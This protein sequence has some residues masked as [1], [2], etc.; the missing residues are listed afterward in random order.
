[1]KQETL[2]IVGGG[3]LTVPAIE[4]AKELGHYTIVFDYDS[5][6][7]GM[8]LADDV[9][10]VS[11][12]DPA[13]CVQKAEHLHA[14]SPI[15][16]VTTAG[17]DVEVTVA[18]IA[19]ALGL[20]G[21]TVE[22]ARLCN[23]KAAMRRRLEKEDVPGPA[24]AEVR[25]LAAAEIA[26]ERIG[27]PLIVKPLDNCGSRGVIRL[28]SSAGLPDAVSN[29]LSLSGGDT[30]LL[31]AFIEGTTHTVEMIA[32]RGKYR[33]C[34]IIDTI[35]GYSPWSVELR[36]V[37]PTVR[38]EADQTAMTEIAM[39][40][41]SAVGI[42]D[43]P[44][45][46]DF[47]FPESGPVVMEMTARLSGGW[48]CQYTTPLAHGTNNIRAAIDVALGRPPRD[49]DIEPSVRRC[50][51]SEAMFPKPG[52]VESIDGLEDARALPGIAAIKMLCGVGDTIPEYQSSADRRVYVIAH[53]DSAAERDDAI[54]RVREKLVIVTKQA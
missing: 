26:A 2:I 34:S 14:G 46:V 13:A 51:V 31:E 8:A 50:A 17:A 53:G 52:R 1:M 6:A 36:H 29:A 16:G 42:S 33:L 21:V 7:P 25:D 20:P 10:V 32:Y 54:R 9:V 4:I 47:L 40:A 23:D 35:H 3:A 15:H 22:A 5:T 38:S 41:L 43:G 30:A 39:R 45:K 27:Y 37:N 49:E 11:T 18:S 12:K 24:F 19:A 28:D 44:A 48:H